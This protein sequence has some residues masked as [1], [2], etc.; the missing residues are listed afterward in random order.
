M[1]SN[2]H[3]SLFTGPVC[4]F[5]CLPVR[6]SGL[7]L[8]LVALQLIVALKKRLEGVWEIGPFKGIDKD[9]KDCF[10]NCS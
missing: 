6:P 2:A 1:F 3:L 4:H 5:V 10:P 8:V 9:N 7:R